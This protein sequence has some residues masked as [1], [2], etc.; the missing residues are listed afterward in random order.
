MNDMEFYNKKKELMKP[1]WTEDLHHSLEEL[2]PEDAKKIVES[3]TDDEIYQ[4]VNNRKFQEDYIADYLKYLF[5]ISESSFWK[6]VKTTLD[7]NQNLLWSDNMFHFKMLCG[8]TIPNDVLV[9]VIKFAVECDE[10]EKLDM[11]TIGCVIKAQVNNFG[12][13][14]EI[15][16]Y[17][18]SLDE[19]KQKAANERIHEMLNCNCNYQFD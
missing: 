7:V 4:K 12:K 5:D 16:K 2:Q 13:L 18:S 19:N 1:G 3:M 15:E 10:K 8:E 14:A 17:I 11:E 6:H 9:A